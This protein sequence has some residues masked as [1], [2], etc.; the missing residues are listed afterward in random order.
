MR[1]EIKTDLAGILESIREVTDIPTA[2]G[3]GINTPQQAT[4]MAKIADGAIVGS[5]IV[6]MIERYGTEAKGPLMEYVA[7]M[8]RAVLQGKEK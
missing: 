6:K 5:A 1:G 2:I 8:K 3:F 4:Q 7:E